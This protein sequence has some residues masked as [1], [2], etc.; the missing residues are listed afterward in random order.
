MRVLFF[1]D[2]FPPESNALTARLYEHAQYWIKAGHEVT[3]VTCAPNFPEGKLMAGYKNRW[4]QV[5]TMDGIRVVRVKSYMAPNRGVVRRMLDFLSFMITATFFGLFER[6]PDV[7]V[8]TSPQFFCAV[9]GWSVA[10][11]KRKPFVLEVRDLWPDSIVALGAMRRNWLIRMFEHLERYLYR[12]ADAIVTVTQGLRQGIVEKGIDPEKIS[13][14][15]N[16]ADL[17]LYFPREPDLTILK[18]YQLN[19][20]FV[21]G[22]IGTHGMAHALDKVLDAV[23]LLSDRSDIV[24]L[25][26]GGGACRAEL[27]CAATQRGL[28]N[29]R[30]V[31]RQP[32]GRIPKLWSV[33][34]VALV[35]LR[36]TP[37]FQ[38][39]LPSKMFEAMG[40]GI[41]LLLAVP[42]GEATRLVRD[43]GAGI[44][45]PPEA[46]STLAAIVGELASDSSRMESLKVASR[47]T[48]L[49]YSREAQAAKMESM[50]RRLWN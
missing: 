38:S 50:L 29:V 47:R 27:E 18:E 37:L 30:M 22:Y 43:S 16:G 36:D 2:N 44:C 21:V 17:S 9:A 42:E 46:P 45:V 3:V 25:F 15:I 32:K 10:A 48:A 31:P 13:L 49:A 35:P 34:D 20:K 28:Q 40:M 26:A 41:P 8:A 4:R 23:E 12:R 6:K 33:C 1:S 11:M 39:A 14:V 24:F 7:V 19:G 5:E